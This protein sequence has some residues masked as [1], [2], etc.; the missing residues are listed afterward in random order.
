VLLLLAV[1]T[2]T[3]SDSSVL[4][5]V[6]GTGVVAFAAL[7]DRRGLLLRGDV[8]PEP[9]PADAEH[10]ATWRSV[11][12]AAYP[13]TLGVSVLAVVA[14][15]AGKGILA[16]LLGGVVA[17]LGVASGVG[18]VTLLAWEHERGA[19]LYVSTDGRRFVDG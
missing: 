4:A 8:D 5:F 2:G 15:V 19:R 16:A 9:L 10:E 1:A 14:L 18:L 3:R 13:S 17:G 6:V 12:S 11:A 7:A